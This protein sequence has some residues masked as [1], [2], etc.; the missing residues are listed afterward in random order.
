MRIENTLQA[1]VSSARLYH[2]PY[3][4]NQH[5]AQYSKHPVGC[6]YVKNKATFF[7]IGSWLCVG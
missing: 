1:E 4:S 3:L 7:D 6:R 5:C 2:R